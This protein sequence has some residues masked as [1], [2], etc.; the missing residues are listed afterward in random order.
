MFQGFFTEPINNTDMHDEYGILDKKLA[1]YHFRVYTYQDKVT[2]FLE[3]FR[4]G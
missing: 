1:Q 3:R 4:G 2:I